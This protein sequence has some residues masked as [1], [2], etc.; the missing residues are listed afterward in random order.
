MGKL[1][2]EEWIAKAKEVHG[3]KYDYSKVKYVNATTKVCIRCPKHDEFLQRPA[4]HLQGKGCPKCSGKNITREEWIAKAKE[5]HGDSYDYSKVNYRGNRIKVLINCPE[6][7]EFWQTPSSHLSGCGCPKCGNA[8]ASKK[9]SSNNEFFITK[10]KKVHGNRYDYRKVNYVNTH[11]KVCIICHEHDEFWQTP[12]SHLQGHG[13]PNCCGSKKLTTED[14]ITKARLIHGDMYDYSKVKYVNNHTKVII[15][16]KKHGDFEQQPY[17][18]LQGNGCPICNVGFSK[19]FKFSLLKKEDLIYMSPHQLIEIIAN[20]KLPNE[21]KA[22]ALTPSNSDERIGCIQD[23]INV[24]GNENTTEEEATEKVYELTEEYEKRFNQNSENSF[25]QNF[26]EITL[27]INNTET[28]NNKV[29]D[30]V[31]NNN[32]LPSLTLLGI[33]VHD[34]L[35]NLKPTD[36]AAKFIVR[37]ELLRIWNDV[38][39]ANENNLLDK[40]IEQI[41]NEAGGEFWNYVKEC[42][43]TEYNEVTNIQVDDEYSFEYEPSLMQK[44]MVYYLQKNNSFGNWCGTGAGKTNAFL[45][46][47]RKT[48]SHVTVAIVPN[49]V[50]DTLRK[51]ILDIYPNSNIVIPNSPND[52]YH[53]NENEYTYIIYNYEKFQGNNGA[54]ETINK[55]IETNKIDFICLD[56]VQ[57]VKVRDISTASSR[58]QYIKNFIARG[59][60]SNPDMKVLTMSA[61]PCIN[62]L[63]EVRSIIEILTGLE[64]EQI[65]N[66]NTIENIHAAYVALV[67]N[68]FR[69]VPK[70]NIEIEERTF[71]IDCSNDKK[72]FE[73]LT[74]QAKGDVSSIEY[75]LAERKLDSIKNELRP[76]TIVYATWVQRMSQMLVNN[77]K[78]WGYSVESYNGE[79][80]DKDGRKDI[81]DR[82]LSGKTDVL[83]C[84]K[85]IST[86]VDGLQKHC[87]KM[88][89]V[90]LPWTDSDYTQLKGR[91]YRQGSVFKK[92][93][94]VIP[95]VVI[96]LPDGKSWSWDKMRKYAIDKKK[97]L[98]TAVVD[99]EIQDTYQINRERLLNKAIEVLEN[100]IKEITFTRNQIDSSVNYTVSEKEYS[101]SYINEVHRR[102]N[103]C[104]SET[105]HDYYQKN[106]N[107]FS[108]YH[109]KRE[110]AKS[111]WIEDPVDRVSEIIKGLSKRYDRIIDMGCGMNKLKTIVGNDRQVQGIDHINVSNDN[112][113]IE[114]DM[115][116]LKGIIEDNSMNVAVFCLSLWGTNYKEYFTE[117]NRIL[118][119]EGKMII[120][121]PSS[122]FGE[123]E[124]YGTTDDFID[125]IETYGFDRIGKPEIR[126]NFIYFRFQKI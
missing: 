7:D 10:A 115:K 103:T 52:I 85:P 77:I 27:N 113:V 101:A 67:V 123:H 104:N 114:A 75:I 89:I 2:R 18:H 88:I 97:S 20:G 8:S 111:E 37:E 61:T 80:G 42:F 59:K 29:E 19:Q 124:R 58:S 70:Y 23:L 92:V 69:Y 90:S 31:Q 34:N 74:S 76:G 22:L 112:T 125:N 12:S 5:V 47:T 107:E 96:N 40:R 95:Q 119:S 53:F 64:Q 84:S 41:K 50:I 11:T 55:L 38:L 39:K 68:G 79:S 48:N 54:D 72:L 4:D 87:N 35:E 94:F 9:L 25:D 117:A 45:F 24:Y 56:E 1:T 63:Q 16:C 65:G 126:N 32:T 99:G 6:H 98:A 26:E 17:N 44:L 21:F 3:D 122:K 86:G 73:E 118:E 36:E 62:N 93:E 105:T 78:Q 116:N 91:I 13:C 49:D 110:I 81:L 14:F 28:T 60:E 15:T 83:V 102:A 106:R 120:V 82:F 108:E 33:H 109:R 71:D 121:E 57:N 100:G 43:L 51:S 30:T 46:A 66:R